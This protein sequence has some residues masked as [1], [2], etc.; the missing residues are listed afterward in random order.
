MV[1][2]LLNQWICHSVE[3]PIE[4]DDND[5][6]QPVLDRLEFLKL[7]ISLANLRALR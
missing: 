2:Y 7:Y 3:E 6:C 5:G 4:N 1:A